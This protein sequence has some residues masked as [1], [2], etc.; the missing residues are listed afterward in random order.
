[1]GLAGV[2]KTI[3]GKQSYDRGT[4][5]RNTIMDYGLLLVKSC[6]ASGGRQAAMSHL[7]FPFRTTSLDS[8]GQNFFSKW[9]I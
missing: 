9:Y 1:M 7:Y 4:S 2:L 8:S 3:R 6:T 5:I